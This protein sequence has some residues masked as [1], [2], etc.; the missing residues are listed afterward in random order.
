MKKLTIIAAAVA[1]A[2]AAVLF[3]TNTAA[4][5]ERY[6]Y[7][8][9]RT[10]LLNIDWLPETQKYQRYTVSVSPLRLLSHGLKFDFEMELPRPGQWIGTSLQVYLAPPRQPMYGYYW[11]RDGNNRSSFNSAF[12]NYHRMWGLGTSVFY[13]NTFS[14]RGWYFSAGI[15]F[16]FHRVGVMENTYLPYREDNLTFYDY[17]TSLVTKSYFKPAL[18]VNIGKHIA[19]SE[20]CYFDLYAGIGYSHAFYKRDGRQM[21]K[22]IYVGTG[23]NYQPYFYPYFNDFMGFAYRGFFPSAGFRFG[24]LLWKPRT[25]AAD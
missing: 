12:D 24:V 18:R 15:T 11:D 17:G 4:A 16:D 21:W 9:S 6:A 1:L 23:G 22:D 5:Q 7:S 13:K 14:H 8:I 3:S 19:L 20:R 25:P 10:R 2:L